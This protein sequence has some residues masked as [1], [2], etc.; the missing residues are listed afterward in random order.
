MENKRREFSGRLS[1]PNGIRYAELE[2]ERNA[3]ISQITEIEEALKIAS[4]KSN[5]AENS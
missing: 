2:N 3:I 4:R 1:E 5:S